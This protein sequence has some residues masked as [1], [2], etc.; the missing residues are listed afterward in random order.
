MTHFASNPTVEDVL[1]ADGRWY[2]VALND[3]GESSWRVHLDDDP[4]SFE[5]VDER[6]PTKNTIG[7][8]S[9]ILAVKFG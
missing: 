3:E 1:L 7:P 8:L 4:P 9:A 6:T 2:S 5:F